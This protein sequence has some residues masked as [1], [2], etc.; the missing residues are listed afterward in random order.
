MSSKKVL[1]L[2]EVYTPQAQVLEESGKFYLDGIFMEGDVKN[3]NGRMYPGDI[4]ER[5]ANKFAELVE[6]GRAVGELDHPDSLTI[7]LDRVSH[8][9]E[10]LTRTPGTSQWAGRLKLMDTPMGRIARELTESGLKLAISSRGVGSLTEDDGVNVVG[11]DYNLITYDLV[12]SPG[13]P[14]AF[15]DNL[16]E[17]KEFILENGRY[18]PITRFLP[19]YEQISDHDLEQ[20]SREIVKYINKLRSSR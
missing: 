10:S 2:K 11:E 16:Q 12:H 5:E 4:L 19:E 13:A 3:N 20:Y 18:Y 9:V 6:Q 14:N 8:L 15:L 7:N 1:L 17:A